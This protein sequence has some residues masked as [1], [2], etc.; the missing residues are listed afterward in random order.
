MDAS[1]LLLIFMGAG[2]PI[3]FLIALAWPSPK[4]KCLHCGYEKAAMSNM[5]D[6]IYYCE[7]CNGLHQADIYKEFAPYWSAKDKQSFF[8]QQESRS[9]E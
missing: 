7:K 1:F 5:M 4:V 3:A 6:G 8:T 2:F 9:K